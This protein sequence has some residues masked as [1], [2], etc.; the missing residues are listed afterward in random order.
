MV[1][2]VERQ[3]RDMRRLA[4]E[5]QR[6]VVMFTSDKAILAAA[7]AT[8]SQGTRVGGTHWK[9]APRKNILFHNTRFMAKDTI[10]LYQMSSS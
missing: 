8:A 6:E 5:W 7:S 4:V 2:E 3:T 10:V 9:V 1:W